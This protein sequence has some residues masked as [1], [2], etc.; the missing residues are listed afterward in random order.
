MTWSVFI[1]FRINPQS[2]VITVKPCH[3]PGKCID[4][5]RQASKRYR[6][7]VTAEDEGG[8]GFQVQV[9]LIINII[10]ANDNAPVF[11]QSE[12][13]TSIRENQTTFVPPLFVAVRNI[14]FFYTTLLTILS[15]F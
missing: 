12:Y 3:S 4:Y 8:E 15:L 11:S 5:E 13:G 10:D 14:A 7:T 9:P 1:S 6:L 2:G